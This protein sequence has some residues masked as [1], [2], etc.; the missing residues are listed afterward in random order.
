MDWMKYIEGGS[1]RGQQNI[2]AMKRKRKKQLGETQLWR[3]EEPH[4]EEGR[5]RE[6]KTLDFL[7]SQREWYHFIHTQNCL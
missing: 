7:K 2:I 4:T 6:S 3:Q 1:Y 5:R